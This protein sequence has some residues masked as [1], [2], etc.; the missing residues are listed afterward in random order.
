M[1]WIW[2]T[3]GCLI[4]FGQCRIKNLLSAVWIHLQSK[5]YRR[6]G[7]IFAYTQFVCKPINIT[8]IYF[9]TWILVTLVR[10]IFARMDSW[11]LIEFLTLQW[12]GSFCKKKKKVLKCEWLGL[13][14]S[15]VWVWN[16]RAC[17][18]MTKHDWVSPRTDTCGLPTIYC[19]QWYILYRLS[20]RL[21]VITDTYVHLGYLK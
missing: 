12:K 14:F 13:V 17:L 3:W 6:I 5:L 16:L 21:W 19:I 8:I 20:H 9:N 15:S 11:I 18:R 4:L 7:R 2:L 1:A 10:R